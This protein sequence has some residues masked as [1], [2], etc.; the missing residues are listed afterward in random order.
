[1]KRTPWTVAAWIGLV[2]VCHPGASAARADVRDVRLSV[3]G[4]T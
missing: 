1:M 3:K 4:A 2:L